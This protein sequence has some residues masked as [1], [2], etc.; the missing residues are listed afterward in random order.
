MCQLQP[1]QAVELWPSQSP[2]WHRS[3]VQGPAVA[4]QLLAEGVPHFARHNQHREPASVIGL[5]ATISKGPCTGM[6]TADWHTML[7][8]FGQQ[9]SHEH[10]HHH[11]DGRHNLLMLSKYARLERPSKVLLPVRLGMSSSHGLHGS[12]QVHANSLCSQKYGT[13]MPS[14]RAGKWRHSLPARTWWLQTVAVLWPHSWTS[15]L[16]QSLR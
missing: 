9:M 3:V 11:Q 4:L 16:A 14:P 12:R 5:H 15:S 2:A 7:S 8:F 13:Q 1:R 10:A 6:P